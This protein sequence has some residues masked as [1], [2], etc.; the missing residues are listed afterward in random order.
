MDTILGPAKIAIVSPYL[1][2][3]LAAMKMNK[4]G[5]SG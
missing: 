5:E 4:N 2:S 1:A 3:I